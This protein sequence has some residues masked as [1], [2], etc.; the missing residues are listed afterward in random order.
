MA[1]KNGAQV[2]LGLRGGDQHPKAEWLKGFSALK[3]G[4]AIDIINFDLTDDS[5]WGKALEGCNALFSSSLDPL[6]ESHMKFAATLTGSAVKHIVR[7]SCFGADTNTNCYNADVHSSIDGA[8]I[9]LMLQHYWWG[10][11]ACIKSGIPTTSI[12]AN[13]FMNHLLKNEQESIKSEGKF[14]TCL[15]DC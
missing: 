13:F 6:I 12:R 2:R 3:E 9:P 15:G 7:I 5:T 4:S 8:K 11:E 14:S 10:E 1:I